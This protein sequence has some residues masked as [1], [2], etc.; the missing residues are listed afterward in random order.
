MLSSRFGLIVPVGQEW[1]CPWRTD[2][3][4]WMNNLNLN[5]LINKMIKMR[6]TIAHL[7]IQMFYD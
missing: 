4:G 2:S 5:Y 1:G 6:G 3:N 7:K